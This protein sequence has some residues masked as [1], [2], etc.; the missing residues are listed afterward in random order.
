MDNFVLSPI[1]TDALIERI[2]ERTAQL[3]YLDP[4][5][6]Q[7][8]DEKDLMTR[9]ETAEF[10]DVNLATLWRWTSQKKL[11]KYGIG[12]KVYYK[13]SEVLESIQSINH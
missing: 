11:K 9:K 13:R 12:N 6:H 10:L 2:A 5:F 1:N 8:D 3:L 4:K 7:S